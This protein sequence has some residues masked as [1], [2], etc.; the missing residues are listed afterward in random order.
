MLVALI[1]AP[2]RR[3]NEIATFGPLLLAA[4]SIAMFALENRRL[5][6][7][8]IDLSRPSQVEISTEPDRLP[9]SAWLSALPFAI[10]VAVALYVHQNWNRIPERFPVHWSVNGHPNRWA[11]RSFHGI[12]GPLIFGA[13]MVVWITILG[14]V[15]WYG[16]RRSKLR[17]VVFTCM[18]LA[19]CLLALTFCFVPLSPVLHIPVAALVLFTV[20]ATVA[21]IIY[22]LT[23]ATSVTDKPEATPNSAWTA[24]MF[25]YNPDDPALCVQRRDGIGFTFNFAR[26]ASWFLMGALVPILLSMKYLL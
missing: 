12:Y 1:A 14:F 2:A 19:A 17:E 4:V 6:R 21:M 3:L 16:A 24:G 25:Y 23:A 20:V 5:R 9:R 22:V 13:E 10:L 18:I 8:A 26:P 15:T 7:M 11:T